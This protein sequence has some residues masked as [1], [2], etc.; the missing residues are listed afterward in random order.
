MRVATGLC[1]SCKVELVDDNISTHKSYCKLCLK[2]INR[3][4]GYRNRHG[5]TYEEYL[6]MV[7]FQDNAC[8]ICRK[9]AR[10]DL[11]HDHIT[12]K[13]RLLLCRRCNLMLRDCDDS[14]EIL[15]RAVAYLKLFK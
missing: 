6:K 13:L 8:A 7:E 11:D 3:E 5:I 4:N 1:C 10:L 2:Q 15:E 14:I 9:E 12:G